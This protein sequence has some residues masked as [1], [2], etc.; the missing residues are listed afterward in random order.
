MDYGNRK[1]EYISKFIKAIRKIFFIKVINVKHGFLGKEYF[2]QQLIIFLKYKP[3]FDLSKKL[4][5]YSHD[6]FN[7]FEGKVH[8]NNVKEIIASTLFARSMTSF[9][10]IIILLKKGLNKEANC[11]LRTF[12][13]TFFWISAIGNNED[14]FA[15]YI[16][17]GERQRI[18]S[19]KVLLEH[20]P[21]WHDI[22]GGTEE[23]RS[24]I[25]SYIKEF[26]KIKNDFG[27]SNNKIDELN[28]PSKIAELAGVSKNYKVLY[29]ILSSD[30]H[31]NALSLDDHFSIDN[32]NNIN[33]INYGAN[34]NNTYACL[35]TSIGVLIQICETILNIFD[36]KDTFQSNLK[37]IKEEY[38]K[39][40]PSL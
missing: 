5:D 28:S 6:I 40:S 29:S 25:D 36:F 24:R 14:F 1:I 2:E 13:E 19:A 20:H 34:D 11:I 4:N 9:Q 12:F 23:L 39:F 3:L 31:S 17:Y 37:R 16:L 7:G 18:K 30:I 21:D 33:T 26:E 10:T 38:D 27:I 32:F 22:I 8:N 35:H 15:K